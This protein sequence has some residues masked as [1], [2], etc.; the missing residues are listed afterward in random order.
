MGEQKIIIK[1]DGACSG[2]PGMIGIGGVVLEAASDKMLYIFSQSK[3][4]ATNNEAQY[5]AVIEGLQSALRLNIKPDFVELQTDSHLI[6]NQLLGDCIIEDDSLISLRKNVYELVKSFD[7][8]VEFCWI[9]QS[10]N[11]M[12]ETLAYKGATMPLA[13]VEQNEAVSWKEDLNYSA[14]VEDISNL[15][16]VNPQTMLQIDFLNKSNIIVPSKLI[17]L[18][19][20]GIDKY[21]RAKF[22]DLLRFIE[23]RFGH[24]AVEYFEKTL[25]ELDN[26]YSKAA[27]RWA[28]R[29]L[30]PNLA[31]RKAAIEME[32]KEN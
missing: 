3:G 12:A 26:T 17:S 25:D 20:F 16:E 22:T 15:P 28:A 2:N 32:I 6:I 14:R 30:N 11:T 24:S 8:L 18:M 29:G 4:V 19:S 13:L 27:L 9:P 10:S 5:L 7:C 23:L 31:L 1:V 21:S